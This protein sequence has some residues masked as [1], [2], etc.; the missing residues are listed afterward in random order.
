MKSITVKALYVP[1]SVAGLS[2]AVV[3]ASDSR[4]RG[5]GFDTW[6]YNIL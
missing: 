3:K 5:P 6:S 2:G 4:A 1:V